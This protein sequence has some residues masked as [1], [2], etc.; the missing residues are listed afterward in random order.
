MSVP[1]RPHVGGSQSRLPVMEMNDVGAPA[2]HA[3]GGDPCSHSRQHGE[4]QPVVVIVFAPVVEVGAARPVEQR[5]AVDQEQ[6][7]IVAMA[8]PQRDAFAEQVHLPD[9]LL[10]LA[11]GEYDRVGWNERSDAHALRQQGF[12]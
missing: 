12:G 8:G 9:Q 2:V 11:T 6:F 4:T 5:G 10:V 1:R 3:F 7:Q